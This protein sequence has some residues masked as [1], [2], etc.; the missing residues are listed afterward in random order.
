TYFI[1]MSILKGYY[2]LVL[3]VIQELHLQPAIQIILM[4]MNAQLGY[5]TT[6]I[7]IFCAVGTNL[8]GINKNLANK[9]D[10]RVACALS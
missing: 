6:K 2:L 8:V 10:C 1:F 9:L 3:M 5:C 7:L 4:V